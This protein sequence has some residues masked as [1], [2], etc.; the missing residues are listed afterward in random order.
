MFIL[1]LLPRMRKSASPGF[2]ACGVL[3]GHPQKN[4]I[5]PWQTLLTRYGV[6]A[7]SYMNFL[8]MHLKVM[9][10]C[11]DW[12]FLPIALDPCMTLIVL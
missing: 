3:R 7:P 6:N 11:V 5:P 8:L 9:P 12:G 2:L 10:C 4:S 1:P